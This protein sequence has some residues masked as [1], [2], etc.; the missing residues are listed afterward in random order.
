MLESYTAVIYNTNYTAIDKWQFN[1]AINFNNVNSFAAFKKKGGGEK[2]KEQ[3]ET[4][5][6]ET[7][8]LSTGKEACFLLCTPTT[9]IIL[10][11]LHLFCFIRSAQTEINLTNHFTTFTAEGRPWIH[12]RCCL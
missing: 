11:T 7:A 10:M 3:G 2:E 6:N 9:T 5:K 1:P 8:P 4:N 12:K